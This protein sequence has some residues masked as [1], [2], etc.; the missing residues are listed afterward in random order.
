VVVVSVLDG[1]GLMAHS[2]EAGAHAF[3]AKSRVA[4]ELP[5]LVPHLFHP[6]TSA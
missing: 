6:P 3:V 4:E 2:R 1:E 5:R